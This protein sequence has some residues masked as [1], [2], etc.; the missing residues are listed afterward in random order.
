MMGLPLLPRFHAGWLLAASLAGCSLLGDLSARQCES[1]ADC[2]H[3]SGFVCHAGV[4]VEPLAMP[5]DESGGCPEGQLCALFDGRPQCSDP[6][7]HDCVLVGAIA[8]GALRIGVL[9]QVPH[10]S[11][12]G[13]PEATVS[14]VRTAMAQ[15]EAMTP[16]LPEGRPRASALVCK[17]DALAYFASVYQPDVW[18]LDVSAARVPF[19]S[20]GDAVAIMARQTDE[21]V[22]EAAR[23]LGVTT[24]ELAPTREASED[25]F[26]SV[27]V[28]AAERTGDIEPDVAL[29]SDYGDRWNSFAMALWTS[30]W[31]FDGNV[32]LYP[33]EAPDR[34]DLNPHLDV[35]GTVATL[36]QDDIDVVVL[37]LE[38]EA[39]D[40]IASL[41]KTSPS[42]T[43]Q[44]V[45]APSGRY[46][47]DQE[48]VLVSEH[49]DR[50]VGLEGW[51]DAELYDQAISPGDVDPRGHNAVYDALFMVALAQRH[52]DLRDGLLNLGYPDGDAT[53]AVGE[54]YESA[55]RAVDSASIRFRGT[56][57]TVSWTESN[58]RRRA[59][60]RFGLYCVTA[61]PL[62]Y[63]YGV[64]SLD[65]GVDASK[66][67]EL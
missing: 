16:D 24:F 53:R 43:R 67:W 49:V 65:G 21:T 6:A 52:A 34:A 38:D 31:A 25:A 2:A 5:C 28:A 47:V 62:G 13:L 29:V 48:V 20:M 41:E 30:L 42:Q 44:Y 11:V 51:T 66:C 61:S 1:D 60:P 14:T 46:S 27:I 40:V 17:D 54:Y 32:W 9:T 35:A 56:T 7:E 55:Q 8:E 12:G 18:I 19:G 58:P 15:I 4:C 36:A 64:S 22:R 45:L 39:L 37:M 50:I 33:A 59:E 10:P 57:G 23:S 3:L 26:K 63:S